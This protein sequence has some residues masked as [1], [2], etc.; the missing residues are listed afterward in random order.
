[1]RRI[2]GFR[3]LQAFAKKNALSVADL[4]VGLTK[5]FGKAKAGSYERVYSWITGARR[6][7][8]AGREMLRVMCGIDPQHG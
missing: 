3:Q 2:S 4:H 7:D 1:M 8:E 5:R 6:P